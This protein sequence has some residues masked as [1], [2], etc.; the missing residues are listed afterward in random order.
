MAGVCFGDLAG[1]TRTR[2]MDRVRIPL[3]ARRV[4]GGELG[5]EVAI[6]MGSGDRGGLM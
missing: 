1:T 6:W 3:V 2:A 5:E 4:V